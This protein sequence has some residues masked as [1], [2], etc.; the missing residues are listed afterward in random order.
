MNAITQVQQSRLQSAIPAAVLR[1]NI[2]DKVL[3]TR[4]SIQRAIYDA[5][6]HYDESV[7]ISEMKDH[8]RAFGYKDYIVDKG[9]LSMFQEG[10]LTRTQLKP[11]AYSLAK[12]CPEPNAEHV[13]VRN[14]TTVALQAPAVDNINALPSM[15]KFNS[16]IEN[17]SKEAGKNQ[18]LHYGCLGNDIETITS[19]LSKLR[20]TCNQTG[21]IDPELASEYQAMGE[22]LDLMMQ[23][24]RQMEGHLVQ[25]A[26]MAKLIRSNPL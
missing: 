15:A 4:P 17:L 2:G 10:H 13:K 1:A 19:H 21:D 26:Q 6:V 7:L 18:G 8:L 23:H 12:N 5:L 22:N 20:L 11:Y 14:K 25:I 3:K 16:H 9:L 24:F